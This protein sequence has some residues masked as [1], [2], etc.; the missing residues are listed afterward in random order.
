MQNPIDLSAFADPILDELVSG[1]PTIDGTRFL[2]ILSQ[3]D[4]PILE[5][6]C[7]YGRIT[8]PLYERGIRDITGL[9][10]CAPSL[11]Y[12]R[13]RA[14]GA[15][16]RWVE[17]DV[18]DFHLDRQFV[19]IFARGDVFDFLLTR[20]DQEAMLANVRA[21]LADGGRFMMDTSALP[22][23]RACRLRRQ[24]ADALICRSQ[25]W[26]QPGGCRW[27]TEE[28]GREAGGTSAFGFGFPTCKDHLL[29]L[30]YAYW[31]C[32]PR[33]STATRR[34]CT[35]GSWPGPGPR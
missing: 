19:F 6:G 4:G 35:A 5:L 33:G 24:T 26:R 3:V 1:E 17:A 9:E 30:R 27:L 23:S 31:F 34:S 18:R 16:I 21:H 11:A 10:L 13:T 20:A 7:G 25:S 8:I 15:P 2:D 12:A 22:P 28:D 29:W 32:G 14:E